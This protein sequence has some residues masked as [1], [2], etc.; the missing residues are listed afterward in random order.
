MVDAFWASTKIKGGQKSSDWDTNRV[1]AESSFKVDRVKAGRP[2][3][4]DEGTLQKLL[5]A[6]YTRPYSFRQLA[7]MFGVSRMTVWRAVQGVQPV[8]AM[9]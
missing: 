9:V 3:S 2:N 6:Y 4:L 5:E 8:G 1:K 7:N